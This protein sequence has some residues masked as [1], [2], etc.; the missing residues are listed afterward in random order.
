MYNAAGANRY[1]TDW[2][3][4]ELTPNMRLVVCALV[5]LLASHGAA[6]RSWPLPLEVGEPCPSR[7]PQAISRWL[8]AWLNRSHRHYSLHRSR[9]GVRR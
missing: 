3:L 9:L 7:P 2:R 6:A 1:N 4:G 8:S 5:V